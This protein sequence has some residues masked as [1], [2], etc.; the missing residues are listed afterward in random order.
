MK[1]SYSFSLMGLWLVFV[2]LC[3]TFMTYIPMTAV[4]IVNTAI[5]FGVLLNDKFKLMTSV[6]VAKVVSS[7]ILYTAYILILIKGLP[8][9]LYRKIFCK[10]Y[11]KVFNM[12]K[13]D[14]KPD[15]NNI[16]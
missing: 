2:A 13:N 11:P 12:T 5:L 1:H 7:F 10:E 15:F 6:I 16:F 9:K 14:C 3:F 4:V 8:L